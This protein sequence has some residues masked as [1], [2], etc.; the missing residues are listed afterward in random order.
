MFG[1]FSE[2]ERAMIQLRV[3]AGLQRAQAEQAAGKVRR[4]PPGRR[5]KAIGPNQKLMLVSPV[6]LE[7]TTPRLK[8]SCSTT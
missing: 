1:M 4:D 2:F 3:K 6:G 8:V 5:L 7:P